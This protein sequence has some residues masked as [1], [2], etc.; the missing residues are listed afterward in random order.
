VATMN[1]TTRPPT[2]DEEGHR[3][4]W[5]GIEHAFIPTSTLRVPGDLR[6]H[7][8]AA[9][10]V[11]PITFE[12]IRHGLWNANQ[13]HGTIL[14]NLA[15]SPILLETRDFQTAILGESGEVVFSGP[16]LQY[17]ACVMDNVVHYIIEHHGERI[18]PGDMWLVNDPWI[19]TAHQ[20]DVNLLCPVFID[21]ELFCWV[22]NNAHQ[23]DVG[24]SLAGSFCPNAEDIYFDPICIPPV[25][26]VKN[27]TIDPEIEALYRRQSRTP[28]SLALDLRASVAGNHAARERILRLVGR[29]GKDVVKAV[30]RGALDASQSSFKELL[31]TIP[32]GE[33]RE[34]CYQEVA[35]VGD[36]GAY[37]I[38]LGVR[39]E[40][41]RLIVSNEGTEGEV[42][43]INLP[44]AALRGT[45]LATLNVL[46]VPEHMG[47]AGGAAR[48][49]DFEPQPGTITCPDYG[50]AVSPAGIFATELG[51]AMANA[52]ITRMLLCSND[53][54][55]R[56][57]A[58]ATT[59]AQWHIHIHAGT[60]QRG[61][62]YVGPM[63]DAMIGTTGAMI[64]RDGSF[65]NG[66]WWIPEGRGPNVEAYE[67]DWPV[68][69]LYRQEDPDSGGAG[70]FRGGNGG[71]LAYVPHNGEMAVGLYTSEGIPK[72]PGIL[73][74]TPGCPGLTRLLTG[75]D[76]RDQFRTGA[77]PASL[78][79]LSGDEI[80]CYGKGAP[81]IVD[82]T[83]V[84]EFN[85]GGS[86]GYGDPLLRDPERVFGDV[87]AGVVSAA[88]AEHQYGVV[89]RDGRLDSG[90]TTDC[91][92]TLRRRRFAGAGLTGEPR[93][94]DATAP[95]DVLLIGDDVWFD[96]AA[97]TY[98]CAHCG[99]ETG[100][101]GGHSKEKLGVW[102]HPV[103]EIGSRFRDP[104]IYVD[105]EIVY[106]ELICPGCATRLATEVCRPG[107]DVL[108]EVRIGSAGAAR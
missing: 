91:R 13:E 23:N 95:Q 40:G 17:L 76:I 8:T 75:S 37:R 68:L 19:G 1:L 6:L 102:E 73:G 25:R 82:D 22:G 106:R 93:A 87:V 88:D 97:G 39:K 45:A 2:E 66:V 4:F 85:W 30:M 100:A 9:D 84:I 70:R 21:D 12:V 18:A 94:A 65:A 77:L 71:R 52:V 14:A 20:P 51:M 103:A 59:P 11:D 28:V 16:Y 32:D 15:V 105:D 89:V 43:A 60:N 62:Y 74:A 10:D 104:S 67:R 72:S 27:D 42:G 63:L 33:W 64:D 44:F 92:T 54:E 86:A 3:A 50:V 96:R 24:G 35:V 83:S 26:I 80:T 98:H 46:V 34:R 36:R 48:Q 78:D 56:A 31:Q 58:L 101:A 108:A 49:V 81:L 41:D 5:N 79:E 69:Y 55:V 57:K 53:P 90:A 38:E 61:V 7:T 29:Y 47:V 99:Q 107:D